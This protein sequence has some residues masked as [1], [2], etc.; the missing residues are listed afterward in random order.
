[1]NVD[2]TLST[3]T[4][5]LM[6]ADRI[7][8]ISTPEDLFSNKD[9]LDQTYKNLAKE[10]HPDIN[11]KDP[12]S[13]DVFAHISV[14]YKEAKQKVLS[15]SW[16]HLGVLDIKDYLG[17]QYKVKYRYQEQFELGKM[18]V[19]DT[20]ICY[21]VDERYTRLFKNGVDSIQMIKAPSGPKEEMVQR[22]IPKIKCTL[23]SDD[24]SN[25]LILEKTPDVLPLSVA[26][27]YFGGSFEPKTAAWI[28]SCLHN[29]TCM[30]KYNKFTHNDISTMTYFISPE[31]HS[32]ILYGGWW[33]ASKHD[34]KL[35][36]VPQ[37][38]YEIMPLSQKQKKMADPYLDS[39]LLRLTSREIL[40]D[41]SGF[42]LKTMGVPQPMDQ[43]IN[44][45]TNRNAYDDYKQWGEV[46]TLAF[47]PRKF[48]PMD[49][50]IKKAYEMMPRRI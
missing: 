4:P 45:P 34:S 28:I 12:K 14:L 18:Y 21:V 48:I 6:T 13:G 8:A 1:M 44:I 20:V 50:N 11:K 31:Y 32:G 17:K 38:S 41:P 3:L 19:A 27:N 22:I 5:M 23:K 7:L 35:V 9:T 29:T 36:G 47:G 15:N 43:W 49:I 39:E 33:Y 10:W 42:K 16:G 30:L 2:D 37:R 24:S 40:G 26:L 46:L 25:I